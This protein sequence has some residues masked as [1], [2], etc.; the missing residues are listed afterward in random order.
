MGGH[1]CGGGEF[2]EC[3]GGEGEG[4]GGLR[5]IGGGGGG[6]NCHEEGGGSL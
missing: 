2:G 1:V 3:L 4:L 6:F 5:G